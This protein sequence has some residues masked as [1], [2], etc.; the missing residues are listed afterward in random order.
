ME[1]K[2]IY[3][4]I[5]ILVLVVCIIVVSMNYLKKGN[6]KKTTKTAT[7]EFLEE[8]QKTSPEDITCIR[9]T[10]YTEGGADSRE[11][12]DGERI[13]EI[14]PLLC[15]LSLGEETQL[16][17]LDDGMSLEVEMGEEKYNYYF[18]GNILVMDNDIRYEVNNMGPL[19]KC[20]KR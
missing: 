5:L 9:V 13:K 18:E 19:V 20:L 12:T 8:V 14:Y 6:Q 1:K 10:F 11:I 17:V 2:N 4:F 7:P 15:D 3:T 16:G